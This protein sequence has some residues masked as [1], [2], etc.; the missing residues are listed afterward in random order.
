MTGGEAMLEAALVQSRH[1]C[2]QRILSAAKRA[3][4]LGAARHGREA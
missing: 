2:A 1:R 4:R 3:L